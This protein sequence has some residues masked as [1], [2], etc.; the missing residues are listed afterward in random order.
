MG[1]VVLGPLIGL[2]GRR[3]GARRCFFPRS[4]VKMTGGAWVPVSDDP[5]RALGGRAAAPPARLSRVDADPVAFPDLYGAAGAG[6]P[7]PVS[8]AVRAGDGLYLPPLTW[9][10][11]TQARPAP[12]E[13]C[14]SVNY[15]HDAAFDGR[16]AAAELADIRLAKN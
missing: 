3:G 16:W 10:C 9:H 7:G 11:F 12:G 2:A 14:V 15:W 5:P 8:V 4:C 13:P 1:L 6:L